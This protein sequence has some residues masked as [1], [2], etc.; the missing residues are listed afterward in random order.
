MKRANANAFPAL[1]QFFTGYLHEDFAREYGT[2]EGALRAFEADA[3]DAERQRLRTEAKRLQAA[4][5][6]QSLSE[7]RALLAGLGARWSPRSTAAVTKLLSAAAG[8]RA[9]RT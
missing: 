3:T 4:I 7:T 8:D 5:D 1:Q 9:K 2:P 6:S